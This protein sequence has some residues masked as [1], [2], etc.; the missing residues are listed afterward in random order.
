[1]KKNITHLLVGSSI[2]LMTLQGCLSNNNA[3]NHS[4]HGSHNHQHGVY[5]VVSDPPQT[6]DQQFIQKLAKLKQRDPVKDAQHA[7]SKGR[8]KLIVKAGRGLNIP[9][10]D[11]SKYSELKQKC[12][13]RRQDGYGDV[14]YGKHHRRYF[15]A[16][17]EYAEKYNKEILKVCS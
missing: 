5:S 6:K 4:S 13:V 3:S 7:I 11:P 17:H 12:G 1:M 2:I 14:L 8:F 9:G 15:S 10:V 16:L